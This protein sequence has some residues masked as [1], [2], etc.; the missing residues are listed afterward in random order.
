MICYGLVR[1]F[2]SNG[3]GIGIRSGRRIMHMFRPMI[4]E[5]SGFVRVFSVFLFFFSL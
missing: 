4:G 1:F 5:M 3:N 2:G